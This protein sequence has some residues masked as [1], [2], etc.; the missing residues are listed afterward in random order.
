MSG[1]HFVKVGGILFPRLVQIDFFES[2]HELCDGSVFLVM[3]MRCVNCFHNDIINNKMVKDNT[4]WIILHL[5]Q[6]CIFATLN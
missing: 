2:I 4:R 6:L 5:A 1:F 3:P